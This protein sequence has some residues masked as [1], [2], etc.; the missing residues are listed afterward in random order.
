MDTIWAWFSCLIISQGNYLSNLLG[1]NLSELKRLRR[2][3]LTFFSQRLSS[4]RSPSPIF[5]YA[6]LHN[7]NS[8]QQSIAYTSQLYSRLWYPKWFI[9]PTAL[10]TKK[11][12][13]LSTH[14][15][16]DSSWCIKRPT[17]FVKAMHYLIHTYAI[18]HN[19]YILMNYRMMFIY[20]PWSR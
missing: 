20:L 3:S 11:C 10:V 19:D 18:P 7:Y 9:L 13:L 17:P 6:I 5:Y 12:I 2:S 4:W 16:N 15:I 14:Q 1:S 8:W